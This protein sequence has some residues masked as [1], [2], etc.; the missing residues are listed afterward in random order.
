MICNLQH[1]LYVRSSTWIPHELLIC[2][3]TWPQLAITV[4]DWMKFEKSPPE[5]TSPNEF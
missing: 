2:Q 1:M 4:S 5:T 3:K